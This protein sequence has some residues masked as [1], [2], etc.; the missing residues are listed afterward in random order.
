MSDDPDGD[1]Q[2]RP[3]I[4][5]EPQ[6]RLV[7]LAGGTSAA[8]RA[9]ARALLA[10]GARVIVVGRDRSKLADL[11]AELPGIHTEKCD[12]TDQSEVRDLVRGL[13]DEVGRVDGVLHLVGGWRGGGGLAGQTEADYRVLE[14]SFT[15]LRNTSRAFYDDLR[16]SSD[17]RIAIVS[18]TAVLRPLA[19][20]A[21]YAAVKAASEAWARA[22]A[23]GFAKAARDDG[24]PLR[25]ASVIYRV[26]SLEGLE[27]DLAAS[28]VGLF[29]QDASAINDTVVDLEP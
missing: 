8:G 7:L 29:S 1:E 3:Y 23:Q 16:A 22:V 20:G 5:R 28:F 25:A 11:A 9:A 15:A 10:A 4:G 24:E 17:G 6:G 19:G 2:A 12:L 27:D 13:H 21:N 14:T 26:K 18:S